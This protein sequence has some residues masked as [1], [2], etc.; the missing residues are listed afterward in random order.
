METEKEL[1]AEE[2][3][4]GK[5]ALC[6]EGGGALGVGHVGAL[7]EWEAMGGYKNLTH[8]VGSSVG[9]IAAAAVAAKANVE[10]MK[11]TLFGLDMNQFEDNS[12]GMIRDL[13]RL[14]K[15]WGWNKGDAI[16]EWAMELMGELTG[17]P[18][19]TMKELYEFGGVH[20]TITYFSYRYR[21]TK[22]ADHITQP[23]LKVANAIRMSS[24]IP[25]YYQAVWR[26]FLN[27]ED[28]L[29][30]DAILDGGT[31]DNFPMH[32]LRKQGVD[33]SKIMGFKLCGTEELNEY[34]A[35]QD[36][37]E[38]DYGLPDGI[39]E[40][41]MVL[42]SCMRDLAMKVHVHKKDWMLTVKINVGDLSSTNFDMTEEQKNWLY[43]NGR[44][45]IRDYLV[46]LDEL[47]LRG[48]Y[49]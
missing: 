2:L 11:K 9:S 28:K 30:M 18:N 17:N 14:I 10:F 1:T 24:S 7:A 26:K 49:S 35:E 45:A 41:L 48:E 40:A 25:V 23:D 4:R 13:Y 15:K 19:I 44:Q 12:L 3:L 33:P 43:E 20:L 6:F 27:K 46:E 29:R 16:T 42:V 37:E 34:K 36:G 38:L 22:Y 5:T 39:V 8:C 32:V 31:M 21:K 47:I